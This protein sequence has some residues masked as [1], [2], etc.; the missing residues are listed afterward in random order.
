[1]AGRVFL[2]Y[3]FQLISHIF[4]HL[5]K[6][7]AMREEE[8]KNLHSKIRERA[9]FFKRKANSSLVMIVGF[10]L[11]GVTIFFYAGTF[12]SIETD[13]AEKF[14]LERIIEELKHD[15]LTTDSILVIYDDRLIRYQRT[16]KI[17]EFRLLNLGDTL[18]FI[19]DSID[20]F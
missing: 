2:L 4:N 20:A 12:A 9:V 8:E 14:R 11:M 13:R 7:V 19:P 18:V 17:L 16:V 5:L 6:S 10:I 3:L 15:R 1:M